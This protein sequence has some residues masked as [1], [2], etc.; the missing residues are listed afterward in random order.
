MSFKINTGVNS[1]IQNRKYLSVAFTTTTNATWVDP[2]LSISV[3]QGTYKVRYNI[4]GTL[5]TNNKN[6]V[7]QM[8]ARLFNVTTGVAIPESVRFVAT[9]CFTKN[10]DAPYSG[11]TQFDTLLY[12]DTPTT[13][14]VEIIKDVVAG[15]TNANL[16]M[17]LQSNSYI[18]YEGF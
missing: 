3:P 14:R 15:N 8:Y 12:S 5:I 9:A 17:V 18:E 7:L 11:S 4:S 13:Y 16:D 6:G 2:S 1:H 10:F